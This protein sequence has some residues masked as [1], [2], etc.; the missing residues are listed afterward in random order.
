ME[1]WFDPRFSKENLR[2][3]EDFRHSD[4]PKRKK[5]KNEQTNKTRK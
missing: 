4:K 1:K 5:T 2:K 3:S